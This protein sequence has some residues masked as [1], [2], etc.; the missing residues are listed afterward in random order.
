MNIFVDR[1]CLVPLDEK[2]ESWATPCLMIFILCIVKSHFFFERT[3]GMCRF[4][5]PL[6]ALRFHSL[7]LHA[8]GNFV[9][10]T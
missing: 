1:S 2:Q 5:R 7:L 9:K 10:A 6:V 3:T 4:F 8:K